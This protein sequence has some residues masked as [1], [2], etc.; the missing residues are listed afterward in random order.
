LLREEFPLPKLT[1]HSDLRRRAAS[2]RA[3]PC[4]SS[5][6]GFNWKIRHG[7]IEKNIAFNLYAKFNGD[8]L[9]N[10]KAIV[11]CVNLITTTP[12]ASTRTTLVALGD[13]FPGPKMNNNVIID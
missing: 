2:R 6:L 4:P 8:R 11:L 10:E 1:F 13:P 7:A 3:L 5:L 12:T 9:W